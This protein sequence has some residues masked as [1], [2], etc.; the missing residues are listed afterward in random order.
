MIDP[1]DLES[2]GYGAEKIF[3]DLEIRIMDDVARRIRNTDVITR[4]ADWQLYQIK[5]M[6]Y[7]NEDIRKM[8]QSSLDASEKYIDELYEEAIKEDYIRYK[9][10]YEYMTKSFVPWAANTQLRNIVEQKRRNT[11]DDFINMTRSLGFVVDSG[12]GMK[13]VSLSNY[14][15]DKLNQ[16]YV[17]VLTGSFDYNTVLRKA[18]KEMTNSG[19]RWINYGSGWHNRITVAARRAVMSSISDVSSAVS[20][21]VALD[22]GTDMY[23]VTAHA[24]ARPTHAVWQGGWYTKRE[25]EEVCGLGDVAGL[26]GA[27]CYHMYYPVIPGLSK[28]TYSQSQLNI[29]R[30]DS[31]TEYEG[32]SY[33]G[34]QATQRMR[35]MET[36]M[37]A[38]RQTIKLLKDNG[39]N[40]FDILGEEAKYRTQM[41]EYAKFCD[42]MNL[43]QQKE[44]IYID[45]K[46]KVA[47]ASWRNK[48]PMTQDKKDAIFESEIKK[49]SGRKKA[50]IS[51]DFEPV[52][53]DTLSFDDIHINS[54]RVHKVTE[55]EAK[56]FIKNAGFKMTV[57][58]G[59][60]DNY[61]SS[62]G[63]AYVRLKDN[64]IRT[65]YKSD[66]YDSRTKKMMEVYEQ[67][68]KSKF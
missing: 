50:L 62:L 39:G 16:C 41:N 2:Y 38:Q 6:G 13:S 55:E 8:V 21:Q 36:N 59:T 34:Y 64:L 65:A 28:H 47:P 14:V 17:D 52:D 22:L 63:A 51:L 18:V 33:T 57:R 49:I 11:V 35:R 23:E 60:Y 4:S 46:G 19:V 12:T 9:P 10:M 32:K 25:L 53:V 31:P 44:R 5:Q 20:D 37:R 30:K 7:S 43:K 26:L 48:G 24:N 29:W 56:S 61:F 1:R 45:G 42:A 27:N 66:E 15:N 67:Y 58:D 54:E 40:K 68:V 3:A